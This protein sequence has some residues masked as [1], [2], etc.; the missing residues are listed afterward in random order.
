MLT[1]EYAEALIKEMTAAEEKC[2]V[3]NSPGF[4]ARHN[5]IMAMAD[6]M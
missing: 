4:M 5:E 3:V 2:L 6:E 1:L